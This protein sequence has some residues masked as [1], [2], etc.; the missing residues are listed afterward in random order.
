LRGALATRQSRTNRTNAAADPPDA[1][2]QR[3]VSHPTIVLIDVANAPRRPPNLRPGAVWLPLTHRD[4]PT[5][6]WIPGAGLGAIPPE[7]NTAYRTRLAALTHNN[8]STKIVIYCHERCWLSWNAAK[9]AISYGYR[10]VAWY[11]DGVEGW[12]SAAQPT[13]I[14]RPAS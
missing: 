13:Q 11:P 1:P 9:R 10:N 4:I 3:A 5:S 8:P 14:A 12:T 6:V 2:N 7:A